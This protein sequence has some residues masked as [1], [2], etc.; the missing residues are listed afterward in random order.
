M[1]DAT[2]RP[3]SVLV[4]GGASEIAQAIVAG[5]VPGRCRTVV[6]AGRPS[7]RLEAAAGAARAAGADTVEIVAFDTTDLA[8]SPAVIEAVFER[9]GDIDLVLAAAGALGDQSEM[10]NDPAAAAQLITTNFTGLAGALLAVAG[11]MRVQGHGRLVVISSV[12]GER[13]RKANFIYGSTKSGLDAFAQG[14]GDSLVGSGVSI[15]IVRP[16][17]VVGRMT[18]GMDPA[19]FS[20]TPDAVANAVIKGIES[21]AEVVYAPP[22]LRWVFAVMRHLPRAVWRRMPG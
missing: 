22:V 8:G 15:T 6:L 16:G 4:L 2:G 18:E 3:Q 17:F 9:F 13:A 19:P 12:A 7:E 1:I 20:T 21:G 5:L 10:E 11:R 14:L